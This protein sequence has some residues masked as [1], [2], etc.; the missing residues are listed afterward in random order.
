VFFTDQVRS[1]S[2]G[3]QTVIVADVQEPGNHPGSQSGFAAINDG[4]A[5]ART[6]TH[7]QDHD[8]RLELS[9][10]SENS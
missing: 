1:H 2:T 10:A 9:T 7:Q 4:R 8:L 6:G 3:G 5:H